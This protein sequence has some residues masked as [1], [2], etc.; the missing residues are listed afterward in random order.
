MTNLLLVEQVVDLFLLGLTKF[1]R[2]LKEFNE[3][4]KLLMK[5]QH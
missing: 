4:L 3:M 1:V 2:L 5:Q